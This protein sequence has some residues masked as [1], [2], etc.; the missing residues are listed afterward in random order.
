MT[1]MYQPP[2]SSPTSRP[3]KRK[4][5]WENSPQPLVKKS[6]KDLQPLVFSRNLTYLSSLIPNGTFA[7]GTFGQMYHVFEF[8]SKTQ[9]RPV[10]Q[11]RTLNSVAFCSKIRLLENFLVHVVALS[12]GEI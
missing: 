10:R 7:N 12:V 3:P 8:K 5:N 4:R 11:L 1:V 6:R 2:K 9:R